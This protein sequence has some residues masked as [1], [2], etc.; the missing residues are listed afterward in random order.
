MHRIINY[1]HKINQLDNIIKEDEVVH[2]SLKPNMHFWIQ[3]N[4]RK[5][6]HSGQ[7]VCEYHI[8]SEEGTTQYEDRH[9]FS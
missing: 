2:E 3:I 5:H 1:Y 8:Q 4:R 6:I 9:K 7:L